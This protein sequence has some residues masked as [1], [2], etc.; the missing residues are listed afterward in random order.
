MVDC[1]LGNEMY[2]GFQKLAAGVVQRRRYV[3]SE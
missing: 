1:G 3:D 2:Q